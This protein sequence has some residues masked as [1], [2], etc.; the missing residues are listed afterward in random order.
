LATQGLDKR[1]Q[2][3]REVAQGWRAVQEQY[4]EHLGLT[5]RARAEMSKP[6]SSPEIQDRKPKDRDANF[7]NFP[8]EL[9]LCLNQQ[10]LALKSVGM[11][12]LP[13]PLEKNTSLYWVAERV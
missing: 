10:R 7:A 4:L 5:Y 1:Q 8:L 11:T 3:R 6:H 13:A 9:R 2:F 12:A